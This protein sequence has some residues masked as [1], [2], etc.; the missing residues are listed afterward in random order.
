LVSD[1]TAYRYESF[2]GTSGTVEF[3]EFTMD[4]CVE[5]VKAGESN[6]GATVLRRIS[7]TEI[8]IAGFA[9]GVADSELESSDI[10][11][12]LTDEDMDIVTRATGERV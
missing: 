9:I 12:K 4:P 8:E 1:V 5:M 7:E 11:L 6:Q 3:D 10:S 2:R